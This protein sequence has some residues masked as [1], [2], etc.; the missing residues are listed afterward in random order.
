MQTIPKGRVFFMKD[1]IILAPS[2]LA[3]NFAEVGAQLAEIKAGGAEYLHLDVMDGFFVPN[4]SFGV[5]VIKS[6]RKATDLFFDTHL[7][8]ERP[9]RYVAQFVSAGSDLITFH[10]EAT[11]DPAAV[12]RQIR[13]AGVKAAISVKPNT[14]VEVLRDLLPLCDMVLVMTVEPGFGGQK[15][16]ADMM[17]KVEKLARWREELGLSYD[18]EVDGGVGVENARLC[19]ESGANVLVAGSSVLGKPSVREAAQAV[20]SAAKQ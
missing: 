12:L 9:E 15:F 5:P 11:E 17:P 16:M 3:A 13:D 14:P 1:H 4:I 8:I 18:I 20:L 10:Y 19:V 2:L 6:L 7:M